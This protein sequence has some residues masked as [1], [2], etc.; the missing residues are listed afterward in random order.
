MMGGILYQ[1][2]VFLAA[3][4]AGIICGMVYTALAG[5]RRLL[6]GGRAVTLIADA[7]FAVLLFAVSSAALA[8]A[9]H[10]PLRPYFFAGILFGFTLFMLAVKPVFKM[11]TD[12]FKCKHSNKA[13]DNKQK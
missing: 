7:L 11:I 3:L 9:V 1:P 2:Y 13:V 10:A 6:G 5:L 8:A 12:V 4:Y